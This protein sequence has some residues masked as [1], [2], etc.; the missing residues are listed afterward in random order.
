MDK[1]RAKELRLQGWSYEKIA[2][3]LGVSKQYIHEALMP[4]NLPKI[5]ASIKSEGSTAQRNAN[6]AYRQ[7]MKLNLFS[8]YSKGLLMCARCGFNDTRALSID[9][10]NGEGTKHRQE[11]GGNI[12]H[13]LTKN[14]YPEGYQV[15]CYNCQAIKRLENHEVHH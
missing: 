15:L 3:E 6:K 12:Y 5:I 10:I 14:D 11:I 7:K 13:W 8:H 9:H 4:F 1:L 2:N